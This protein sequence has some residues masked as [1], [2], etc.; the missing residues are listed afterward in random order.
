MLLDPAIRDWVLIPIMI[1]MVLVGVV[2]HQVTVL[3]N[4]TP[5]KADLKSARETKALQRC[6]L[7]RAHGVHIP[8]HAF[9]G[10]KAFL[11]EAFEKGTYLKETNTGNKP[12]G[13]VMQDPAYVETMMDG[14]KKNMMNIVPQTVIMGWI[15]FFFSGFVLVKLPFPLTVRFKG[16]L[17]RGV[18]THDMDVSWVSSLS[19]YFLNLFGLQS[20]FT[21]ILG[22]GHAADAMRDM[23]AMSTMGMGA[24]A[25]P[26]LSPT[27]QP[28]DMHKI[29]LAEKEN[30]DLTEHEWGLENVETRL[31]VKYGKKP[32]SVLLDQKKA[33]IAKLAGRQATK[34]FAAVAAPSA[35]A[36][37]ASRKKGRRQV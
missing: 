15:N 20:V 22:S 26:N 23:Q 10:R 31:L 4:G 7:L 19:W 11:S 36:A 37:N 2:R 14:M 30:L 6:G 16:M 17:Q 5:K 27:G 3:L 8:E 13:N 32:A 34:E 9:H 18:E 12:R 21:L 25:G 24:A 28:Q 33:K 29:F 35:A 1:V